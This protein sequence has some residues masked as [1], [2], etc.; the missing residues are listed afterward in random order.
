M[1]CYRFSPGVL[2]W[3]PLPWTDRGLELF[4]EL[5]LNP[6][7]QVAERLFERPN[8]IVAATD[9]PECKIIRVTRCW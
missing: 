5:A 8:T 7:P 1:I 3:H 4:P 6:P 9:P 2:V